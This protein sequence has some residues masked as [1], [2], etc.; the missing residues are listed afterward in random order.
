[1]GLAGV[2]RRE[3]EDRGDR[4]ARREIAQDPARDFRVTGGRGYR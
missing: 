4:K 3:S 1:M 2:N